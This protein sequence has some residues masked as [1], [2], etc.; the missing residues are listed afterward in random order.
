MEVAAT[1]AATGAALE[2]Q[3]II[4]APSTFAGTGLTTQA[5]IAFAPFSDLSRLANVTLTH[6]LPSRSLDRLSTSSTQPEGLAT[7]GRGN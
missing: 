6:P 4:F 1:K 3:L 2:P 5:S 7:A